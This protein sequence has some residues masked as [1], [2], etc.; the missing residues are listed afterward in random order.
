[1]DPVASLV[2]DFDL[3]PDEGP[4]V[5]DRYPQPTKNA[6]GAFEPGSPSPFNLSPW[7]AHNVTGRDL[8]QLPE[9]DRNSEIVQI[10]A[11]NSSFPGAIVKGFRV[12]DD[13]K[14][15]DIFTYRARR[16]RVIMVRD[17]SIQG[18]VWCAWGT[19]EDTASIT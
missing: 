11:N 5:V 10:Y 1:M 6:R 14:G 3:T 16:Y 18:R 8:L 15:A 13:G 7:V 4:C 17:F 19:L 2:N 12:A 9:A